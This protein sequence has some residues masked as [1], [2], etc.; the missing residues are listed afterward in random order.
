MTT[1]SREVNGWLSVIGRVMLGWF[2]FVVAL[3]SAVLVGELVETRLGAAALVRQSVQALVLSGLVVPGIFILRRTGNKRPIQGSGLASTVSGWWAFLFGAGLVLVL[4]GSALAFG[5]LT[6]ELQIVKLSFS[7]TLLL[8]LLAEI[9][10]AFFYEALPEELTFRGY[11][12]SALNT[13]V[14]R[15]LA[16]LAQI[17]L[18]V[19]APV[20][21][22]ALQ[23]RFG[24]DVQLGGA[25]KVTLDYL[26]LL[27]GFGLVLQLCRLVTGSLWASIGFH[28][29]FLTLN[30]S[31][32]GPGEDALV[33]VSETVPLAHEFL[34]FFL[35][36]IVI[37]SLILFVLPYL[38]RRRIGWRERTPDSRLR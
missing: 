11:L 18:F 5:V 21:V 12:Y 6:G 29:T 22:A 17:G 30:P 28:L 2:L 23:Q 13:R 16:L 14:A 24:L 1:K 34:V 33:Q 19:L 26:I 8:A 32:I 38:R 20:T 27:T 3:L 4:A 31:I 36:P 15:W 7:T 35:G 37:G 10:V 9:A 25:N